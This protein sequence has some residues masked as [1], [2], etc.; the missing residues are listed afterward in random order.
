M[1][2]IPELKSK[3]KSKHQLLTTGK[4]HMKKLSL[5]LAVTLISNLPKTSLAQLATQD[6]KTIELLEAIHNQAQF[7]TK[8]LFVIAILLIFATVVNFFNKK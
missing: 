5:I 8:A 7:Q 4:Y 3:G 2:T 6:Q 1:K